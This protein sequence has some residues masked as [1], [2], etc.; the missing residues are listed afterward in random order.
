ME[1]AVWSD[2]FL[3]RPA[4]PAVGQ[5]YSLS[6]GQQV[7]PYPPGVLVSGLGRR[8]PCGSALKEVLTLLISAWVTFCL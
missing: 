4:A 2:P 7:G 1:S 6:S 3:F 5:P 8:V